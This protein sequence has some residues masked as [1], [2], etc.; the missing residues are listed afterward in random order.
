MRGAGAEAGDPPL[1]ERW[2]GV[3]SGTDAPTPPVGGGNARGGMA[4][5]S[6]PTP[7]STGKVAR[8]FLRAVSASYRRRA[9]SLLRER[10]R[11]PARGPPQV[12]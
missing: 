3:K 4:S 10:A 12:G 2:A 7:P 11:V 8:A 1:C 5:P 9:R 6:P